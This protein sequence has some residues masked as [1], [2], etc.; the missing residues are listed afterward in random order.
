MR[1]Y[2]TERYYSDLIDTCD[3]INL[4]KGIE[5][6]KEVFHHLKPLSVPKYE[7]FIIPNFKFIY[8]DENVECDFLVVTKNSIIILEVKKWQNPVSISSL[9]E[10]RT[11]D[12]QTRGNINA[13][14]NRQKLFLEEIIKKDL[15]CN[16]DVYSIILFSN[17]YI[18]N[19]NQANNITDYSSVV[20]KIEDIIKKS[21]CQELNL[22]NIHT[23]LLDKNTNINFQKDYFYK[24]EID[25]NDFLIIKHEEDANYKKINIDYVKPTLYNFDK[26]YFMVRRDKREYAYRISIP[27]NL[28]GYYQRIDDRGLALLYNLFTRGDKYFFPKSF[29]EELEEKRIKIEVHY[30]IVTTLLFIKK[31]LFKLSNKEL[32]VPL[33]SEKRVIMDLSKQII[34]Y[35]L[36]LFSSIS[37]IVNYSL[38]YDKNGNTVLYNVTSYTYNKDNLVYIS[39]I[40]Q[41][42][43]GNDKI[44]FET[45]IWES[46]RINYNLN[47]NLELL[48]EIVEV[49]FGFSSYRE[50]QL[51]CIQT[52]F[53]SNR[54]QIIMLPT[55]QGKSMIFY[56]L[57]L[58]QPKKGIIVYP[59]NLL[60]ND[61][62]LKLH[63][64]GI[65]SI[66]N[67]S[68]SKDIGDLSHIQMMKPEDILEKTVLESFIKMNQKISISYLI[69]DEVHCLSK[70]SHDFRP[71]YFLMHDKINYYLD[72]TIVKGF[73][74]TATWE[75]LEDLKKQ[76][77]MSA[78]DIYSPN[79]VKRDVKYIV[80]RIDEKRHIQMLQEDIEYI[81][82]KYIDD[83]ILV[84]SNSEEEIKNIKDKLVLS[85]TVYATDQKEFE[86]NIDLFRYSDDVLISLNDIGIGIDIPEINTIIHYTQP[87]SISDFSQHTGRGGR[88]DYS[89]T[90]IVYYDDKDYLPQK[91]TSN[92]KSVIKSIY[93]DLL[94]NY[95]KGYNW[96]EIK[97]SNR[98]IN[99]LKFAFFSF[100]QLGI[101]SEWWR[102]SVDSFGLGVNR[103]FELDFQLIRRNVFKEYSNE[104]SL[105]ENIKRTENVAE[106]VIGFYDWFIEWNRTFKTNSYIIMHKFLEKIV[107]ENL[108][109]EAIQKTVKS[110]TYY[111]NVELVEISKIKRMN[112][113][114]IIDFAEDNKSDLFLYQKYFNSTDSKVLFL[115]LYND[116]LSNEKTSIILPKF[117]LLLSAISKDDRIPLVMSLM[118]SKYMSEYDELVESIYLKVYKNSNDIEKK[119]IFE[120]VEQASIKSN[121]KYLFF[122]TLINSNLAEVAHG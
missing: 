105:I 12:N 68:D 25:D 5:G 18:H 94:S 113:Q 15:D 99:D 73:T 96:A 42:S 16:I 50:G 51:E 85:N 4:I 26:Y 104:R 39:A 120:S 20:Q 49:L 37:D 1:I 75:V 31:G 122:F 121:L 24:G 40:D 57:L 59:T 63:S 8:G 7:G 54:N 98:N 117:D 56:L 83:K 11:S 30:Y 74:A 91:Q 111:S 112:F 119:R 110:E 77:Y 13:Q 80:R 10:I 34:S 58:L 14:I 61:Q 52:V 17:P 108:N 21:N 2:A 87:Y 46:D 97:I 118:K 9:G 86:K 115:S 116:L 27:K 36:N 43:S 101:I 60:I 48:N 72:K 64:F 103:E 69:L 82:K 93:D 71:E 78:N 106:L 47:T 70:F 79:L 100:Y 45:E 35:W 38:D 29:L 95:Q 90:S 62:I 89:C 107:N 6:E 33:I 84:F 81:R 88:A 102:N 65:Y 22:E 55:G 109:N 23:Y 53:N 66:N 32:I 3:D 41:M 67:F 76:F 44:K 19:I 92:I 114:Q 28:K